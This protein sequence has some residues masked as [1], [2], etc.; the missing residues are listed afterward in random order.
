MLLQVVQLEPQAPEEVSKND[1][2]RLRLVVVI[3]RCHVS[4]EVSYDASTLGLAVAYL[5]VRL[6][7]I[8]LTRPSRKVSERYG[9]S[10]IRWVTY[11]TSHPSQCGIVVL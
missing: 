1:I 10:H 8:K 6:V 11:Y 4:R 7:I 9:I 3:S 2:L 5:V